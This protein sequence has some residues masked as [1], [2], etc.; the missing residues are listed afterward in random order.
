MIGKTEYRKG[1]REIRLFLE[2]KQ[3]RLLNSLYHEMK[4]ASNNLNYEKAAKAR[5]KIKSIEA[6]L[7]GQ[8]ISL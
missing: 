7:K 4:K 1:I 8:E 2:G 3:K 5:D 6:I